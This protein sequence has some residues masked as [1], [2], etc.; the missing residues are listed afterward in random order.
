MSMYRQY[1]NPKELESRLAVLE[2]KK[3]QLAS[4]IFDENGNLKEGCEN[5]WYD[6]WLELGSDIHDLEERIN[7]A[8][9]DEEYEENENHLAEFYGEGW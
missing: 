7:F 1:E 2:K 3:S 4:E 9:Q 6:E 5:R 8:Y